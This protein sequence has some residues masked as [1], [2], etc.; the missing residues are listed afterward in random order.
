MR[1]TPPAGCFKSAFTVSELWSANET[2]ELFVT[3]VL[4]ISKVVQQLRPK[5]AE[6]E[7]KMG[8]RGDEQLRRFFELFTEE[9][10]HFLRKY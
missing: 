9:T 2:F 1:N 7:D 5:M 6:I 8:G 10:A 4:R 3:D